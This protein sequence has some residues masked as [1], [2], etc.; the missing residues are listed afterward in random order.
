MP[1][2][3]SGGTQLVNSEKDVDT[4][5]GLGS[6]TGSSALHTACWGHGSQLPPGI[7]NRPSPQKRLRVTLPKLPSR[8]AAH[9]KSNP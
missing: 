9:P 6:G 4:N 1:G 8:S 3:A 7:P 5:P 2:Q